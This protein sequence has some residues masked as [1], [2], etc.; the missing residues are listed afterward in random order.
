MG[1]LFAKPR[2]PK[3]TQANIPKLPQPKTVTPNNTEGLSQFENEILRYHNKARQEAG[4]PPLVWDKALKQ[5][6]MDWV[7][8]LEN[9]SGGNKCEDLYRHPGTEG[10]PQ[11]EKIKFLNFDYKKAQSDGQNIAKLIPGYTL[12][13]G[14]ELV[15]HP[16][17]TAQDSIK[18]WYN[19]CAFWNPNN[20][21][22]AGFPL[23]SLQVGHFTQ[24]MWKDAK[25][26]GCAEF[27]CDAG[28]IP[29]KDEKRI[30]KLVYC[31]YDRGNYNMPGKNLYGE[32]VPSQPKCDVPNNWIIGG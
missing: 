5:R 25:K 15:Y 20:K 26:L 7:T 1:H 19:E 29:G 10:G 16:I 31:N 27:T 13:G 8:Y 4:Y 2:K 14:T 18:G 21:D 12:K 24:L 6:T 22:A 28:S 9:Q 3:H 30:G 11:S 23:N 17:N 32:N